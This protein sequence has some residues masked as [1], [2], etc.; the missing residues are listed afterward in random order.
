M[1]E[2]PERLAS[3][4]LVLLLAACC[5]PVLLLS[6]AIGSC[7]FFAPAVFGTPI[8]SPT[9]EGRE[10]QWCL[11]TVCHADLAV[12]CDDNSHSSHGTIYGGFDVLVQCEIGLAL[13]WWGTGVS[14]NRPWVGPHQ[15]ATLNLAAVAGH[16]GASK[17]PALVA[18]SVLLLLLP[19]TLHCTMNE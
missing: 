8:P 10:V 5:C 18:I 16:V 14:G 11:Y 1:L 13:L 9:A 12:C 7:S 17:I 6:R 4:R 3:C 19:L 15:G 2:R